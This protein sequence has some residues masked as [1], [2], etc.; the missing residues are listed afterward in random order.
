MTRRLL[1]ISLVLPFLAVLHAAEKPQLT[2]EQT[3]ITPEGTVFS[4]SARLVQGDFVLTADTIT[5]A[6]K[7]EVAVATGNVIL[8]HTGQR[9]LADEITYR[10]SDQSYEVVRFRLGRPPL[11]AEG[12]RVA[13][14]PEGLSLHGA[15]IFYGEPEALTPSLSADR[16]DVTPG[17]SVSTSS[18]RLRLGSMPV[19]ATPA[20]T[21]SLHNP[22]APD[23]NAA[24]GSDS[25]LGVY[26]ELGA[27]FP[28]SGKL[29]V[30]GD[31]DLYS[32]R[33]VMFGPA[34]RYNTFDGGDTGMKGSLRSG[35][36]ND[37][38]PFGTDILGA[39]IS[40]DRGFVEWQ[41]RQTLSPGL[42]INGELNYWSDSEVVRDFRNDDFRRV[43]TPDT[44]LETTLARDNHVFSVFLRAQPNDYHRMQERLPEVRFDGLPIQLG[45]GIYHR[46]NASAVALLEEDPAGVAPDLR[47]DRLDV[48][49]SLTRPYSPRE[50]LALTPVVGG[51]A[52]HY[53]RA[54][55]RDDYTRLLGEIGVDVELRA[56]AVHNTQSETW[57][58]NGLRHLVTPRLSYRYIP[59]ADNGRAYIPAIDREIF[60]TYLQP[61]GLGNRRNIDDLSAT[62]TL[63]VGLDNVLQTRSTTYGSRNLLSLAL[64]TDIYFDH[65]PGAEKTSPLHAALAITP[66]DWLTFELYQRYSVQGGDLEE[67]NTGI[68]FRDSDVWSLR[69]ANHYL[70]N[71][72]PIEEYTL[73]YALRL[74]EIY[75]L[76]AA[77]RYDAVSNRFIEQSYALRQRFTR[78][79]TISYVLSF[80]EGV[81]R[82]SDV[83]FSVRFDLDTF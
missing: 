39:P 82:E 55:G 35:Y 27:L 14:T 53:N 70:D 34:A 1:L 43:Q 49:Y 44:W 67:I 58:I 45:A 54:I 62:N 77:I 69:I 61:L 81:T 10:V 65:R 25:N 38:D 23:I 33:G 60:D 74:N 12:E 29:S 83:S 6:P 31:I 37:Q 46:I 72:V 56:S 28:V 26:L 57:G 80:N 71:A 32:D 63:R 19:F 36:I 4:G 42:T 51:R 79:W 64:A 59:Q 17:E 9:L 20:F 50:W 22:Q 75:S 5:Y 24:A 40:S 78:I 3:R 76:F 41:H 68:T 18:G 73:D 47:S 11:Y 30:G 66:A 52:T 48:Y 16:V 13:G 8:T 7:A 2:A 21:Q 15:R